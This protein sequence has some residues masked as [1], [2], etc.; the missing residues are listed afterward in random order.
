MIGGS[1]RI[2]SVGAAKPP[3]GIPATISDHDMVRPT[4]LFGFCDSE[5]ETPPPL[6]DGVPHPDRIELA[7]GEPRRQNGG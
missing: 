4:R 7:P 5:V 1:W 6:M 3:S 2:E